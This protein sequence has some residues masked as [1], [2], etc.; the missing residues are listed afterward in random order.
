MGRQSLTVMM[1]ALVLVLASSGAG[2]AGLFH[3][4]AQ[5]YAY[6]PYSGGHGYSYNVA[7]SY[8]LCFSADESSTREKISIPLM[9]MR[10]IKDLTTGISIGFYTLSRSAERSGRRSRAGRGR[11]AAPRRR[12]RPPC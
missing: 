4:T 12:P 1:S 3:F 9:R 8:G 2:S 11:T 5:D 6:G 7:Y 10:G